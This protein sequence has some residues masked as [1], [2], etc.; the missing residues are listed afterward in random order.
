MKLLIGA[1]LGLALV[2]AVS[3]YVGY[4]PRCTYFD[5]GHVI[6]S[7]YVWGGVKNWSYYE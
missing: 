2:I 7:Q 5:N 1:L 4:Q 6:C 3:V